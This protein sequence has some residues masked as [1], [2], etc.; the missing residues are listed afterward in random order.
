VFRADALGT[1]TMVN[2]N[3][4]AVS[5]ANG[6]ARFT[7]PLGAPPA[8]PGIVYLVVYAVTPPPGAPPYVRAFSKA[9]DGNAIF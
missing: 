6:A 8:M 1:L 4:T 7:L 5:D 2:P 3:A 9:I